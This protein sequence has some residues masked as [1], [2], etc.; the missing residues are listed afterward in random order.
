MFNISVRTYGRQFLAANVV[1]TVVQDVDH[2]SVSSQ[3]KK[4]KM[5]RICHN[6]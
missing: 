1:S 5:E 4:L 3:G 6:K 2:T